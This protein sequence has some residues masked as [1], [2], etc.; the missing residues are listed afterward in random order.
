[1]ILWVYQGSWTTIVREERGKRGADVD[2]FVCYLKIS[3]NRFLPSLIL[4]ENNK[5]SFLYEYKNY[6]FFVQYYERRSVQ[7]RNSLCNDP[8]CLFRRGERRRKEGLKYRGRDSNL[9]D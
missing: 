4:V 2:D 5:I 1:M 9:A 7:C 6:Y 8:T 3:N